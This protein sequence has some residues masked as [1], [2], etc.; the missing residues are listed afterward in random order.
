MVKPEVWGRLFDEQLR[1]P[2]QPQR[3]SGGAEGTGEHA[4]YALKTFFTLICQ[5]LNEI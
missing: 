5:E 2:A 4:Q 1:I 3:P